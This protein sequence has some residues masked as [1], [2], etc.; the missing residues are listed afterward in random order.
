M[1]HA[2]KRAK[3]A[4]LSEDEFR[5]RVVRELFLAQGF[6]CYRDVCGVDE[7]GK[8][9]ILFKD[10][11]FGKRH[12]YVVQTKTT[13][14]NM[15]QKA[16]QNVIEAITQL[17]TASNTEVVLLHNNTKVRPDYVFL[18]TSGSANTSARAEIARQLTGS[19]V[20]ILD[21]DE[22]IDAIDQHYK[23]F[24][25]SISR[26]NR[27]Y[28][29]ELRAKLLSMTDAVLLYPGDGHE[30]ALAPF[31]E[32]AYVG[33]KLFRLTTHMVVKQGVVKSEPLIEEIAD[34]RLLEMAKPV[35]FVVGDGGT[36]KTT[37][38]R[39]L[40]L[41]SCNRS[42][43]ATGQD[44]CIIPVLL[45]AV[46]LIQA[47]SL[48]EAAEAKIAQALMEPDSGLE[49]NDF[50]SGRVQVFIDAVDEAGSSL[51]Y[52]HVLNLIE[53][54]AH[55]YPSCKVV[56]SSRPRLTVR[57]YATER[58]IPIYE[59][60]DFSIKQ[61]SSIVNR[62]VA[63][64][65]IQPAAVTE[66]LRKLQ[67]VH[68]MKLNPLL[69]TV[70][71]ATPNFYTKDIPPNISAIFRKFAAL[72]LG[73]WDDRKGISVQY[74]WEEKHGVL[75]QIALGWHNRRHT[76]KS[77]SEFRS[78]VKRIL[79]SWGRGEKADAVADEILR[80]GLL[81]ES[82]ERVAFRHH[83]FQEYFAGASIESVQ[84]IESVV[85][86]EWW[87]NAIV[88]AYGARS[89][90]GDE[91]AVLCANVDVGAGIAAYRALV[92]IGLALQ[93]CYKT[94]VDVRRAVLGEVILKLAN[95]FAG[96]L[97]AQ[98][99][100][101]SYPLTAFIF[102]FLE[103]RDSVSS[104][105]ILNVELGVPPEESAE[106]AEFL[107]LAGAIESGHIDIVK[108]EVLAFSPKDDRLL[109]GLHLLA[110]FVMHL[111]VSEAQERSAAKEIA[112][113]ITPKIVPL[114]KQVLQE[115][116]GMVLELQKGGIHVLDAPLVTPEGQFEID[117]D[118]A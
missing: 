7:E 112:A 51:G 110:F 56:V 44:E 111:R 92:T 65:D 71:A 54:F 32:E 93:A 76:E 30:P 88:F 99:S 101:D 95:C 96:F 20:T 17:K 75:E 94:N 26:L 4:S 8:D 15:S 53:S 97:R 86:D 29:E 74:E 49:E 59:I 58:R 113:A 106:H 50:T 27:K 22:L 117:F 107:R 72:M 62:A 33:Q 42:L 102:H 91:L 60:S 43:S 34:E 45:R 10:V 5:D 55:S 103:A 38:L 24:W 21:A 116:K 66:V 39:R 57:N 70:F 85:S 48:R 52:A 16:S 31:A 104:D 80:S 25:I 109:L 19:N 64:K 114:V 36:G 83:L 40:C 105:Q 108:S 37:L 14:L 3:L 87:R 11:E 84:D 118:R 63:G 61:A 2:E 67:D 6:R 12:V 115:F 28:V 79:T 81:V 41:L 73:Q 18:C 46:D 47:D 78:D 9:C 13:K 90:R 89:T 77:V 23:T 35:A 1:T 68:G 100:G 69:V 82:E 98:E